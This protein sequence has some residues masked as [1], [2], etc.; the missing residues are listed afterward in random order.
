MPGLEPLD[1]SEDTL[2]RLTDSPTKRTLMSVSEVA[3]RAGI[4]VWST[5]Q[6]IRNGNL[7]RQENRTTPSGHLQRLRRLDRQTSRDQ[8]THLSLRAAIHGEPDR[9]PP[10]RPRHPLGT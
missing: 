2:I 7:A 6:Q 4:S 10:R 9:D 8:R 5:R 1:Q 3:E